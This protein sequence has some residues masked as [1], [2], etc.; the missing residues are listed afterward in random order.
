MQVILTRT[1]EK[2]RSLKKAFSNLYDDGTLSFSQL[3]DLQKAS[4]HFELL[5]TDV[6]NV[7]KH[8]SKENLRVQVRT[9]THGLSSRGLRIILERDLT[10]LGSV[11]EQLDELGIECNN[12]RTKPSKTSPEAGRTDGLGH[13]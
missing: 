1:A 8:W 3:E 11:G 6:R 13:G 5:V 2:V 12:I 7:S 10:K 4:T 9:T